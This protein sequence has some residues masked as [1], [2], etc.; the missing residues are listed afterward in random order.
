MTEKM[1]KR[2]YNG[3]I[4]QVLSAAHNRSLLGFTASAAVIRINF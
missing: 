3:D 2:R 1:P 4:G